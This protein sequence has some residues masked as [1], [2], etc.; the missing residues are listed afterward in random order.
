MPQV[1]A[2][3]AIVPEWE[4]QAKSSVEVLVCGV[5]FAWGH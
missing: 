4:A 2:H 1:G 3:I 5:A